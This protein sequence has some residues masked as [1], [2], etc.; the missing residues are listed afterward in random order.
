MIKFGEFEERETKVSGVELC[1]PVQIN[2]KNEGTEKV[3]V[4]AESQA[5]TG[6]GSEQAMIRQRKGGSR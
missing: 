3:L 4:S 5:G 6:A 2:G 1:F